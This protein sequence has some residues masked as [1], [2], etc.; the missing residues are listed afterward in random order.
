MTRTFSH[1]HLRCVPLVGALLSLLALASPSA[2]AQWTA[3]TPEELSM[4]VQPEVPG[5]AA[6]YLFREETTEDKLRMFSV[7]ARIKVLTEKGKEFSTIELPSGNGSVFTSID[8]V[9][10]R[11][12]HPDGTIISLSAKPYEKLLERSPGNKVLAKVITLPDVEIGS[13]IEYRY[14]MH[15][16]DTILHAPQWYI[17]STLWTRKAHYLWR[18]FDLSG[19]ATATSSRGERISSIFWTPILPAG[20]E[21]KL[22]KAP[23]GDSLHDQNIIELNVH[24]I[25]PVPQEAYMPPVRS[26]TYRV[27]FYFSSYRSGEEFWKEEGKQWAKEED[28]FIGPG[29]NVTAATNALVS[30]SDTQEQKLHKIYAAIMQFENTSFTFSHSN[31]ADPQEPKEVR[32]TEDVWTRKRGN[33]DQLTKLFVAMA[34]AAGMKAYVASVTDRDNNIFLKEYLSFSQLNGHIAIVDVDG[35]ELFFDPGARYCPFGHLVWQHTATSGIRQTEGGADFVQTPSESYTF[36]RTL[37]AGNLVIDEKGKVTG[38]IKMSYL[39]YPNLGWRQRSLRGGTADLRQAL[40][41]NVQR[42]LPTSVEVD[43][44]SIENLEDYEKPLVVNLEVK[45]SLASTD[46]KRLL[47][48]A[49]IFEVNTKPA[50]LQEKREISV[51]FQ[52]PRSNEDM[53]HVNFAAPLS[54][55]WLPPSDKANLQRIAVYKM[56]TESNATSFTIR[57]NYDLGGIIVHLQEYPDLRTFYSKMETKD[58]ESVVLTTAP[59]STKSTPAGN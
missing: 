20:T 32:T 18:P 22:S 6:V 59:V 26:L 21:V 31:V 48:P 35:K 9:Q 4:T 46:G 11:T 1:H 51:Y 54:I 14:K 41:D 47:I 16:S 30:V 58:Q 52:Y 5:A 15:Y 8:E 29:P 36:S 2:Y 38:T 49:D 37:R 42:L 28:K 27:L 57:R 23:G 40:Q 12:I 50:F 24:D 19:R 56:S 45:G 43:V 53:V 10:G 34:R 44:T 13:I 33:N 39:G 17:Q 7:Y 55:E 3:P 25:P